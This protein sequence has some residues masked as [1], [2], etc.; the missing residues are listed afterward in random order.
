MHFLPREHA[1]SELTPVFEQY[2]FANQLSAKPGNQVFVLVRDLK[3]VPQ[4]QELVNSRSNV[5]AFEADLTDLP[6]L[7]VSVSQ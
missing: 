6:S 2:E 4:L 5:W 1:R 3:T 7:K